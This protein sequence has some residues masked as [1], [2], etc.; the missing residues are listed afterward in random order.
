M[1]LEVWTDK[2]P[3]TFDGLVVESFV[4]EG[5]RWHVTQVNEIKLEQNRKGKWE[6]TISA[7]PY[8]GMNGFGIPDNS[9]PGM[10]QLI[11]EVNRVRAERYSLAPVKS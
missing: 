10:Q 6:I 3:I 2:F 9:V 8:G 4:M 1:F 5:N 11:A 7:F